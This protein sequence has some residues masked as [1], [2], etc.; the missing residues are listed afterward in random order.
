MTIKNS[1]ALSVLDGLNKL[2]GCKFQKDSGRLLY[3][4]AKNIRLLNQVRDDVTEAQKRLMKQHSEDRGVIMNGS[5]AAWQFQQA[6][7]QLMRQEAEVNLHKLAFGALLVDDN[8]ID[9]STL[10]KLDPIL[11][12][13]P[14][15]G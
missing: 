9:G 3:N 8:H 14:K 7:D 1:D 2:D 11:E 5:P 6:V 15:D 10:A 12:E 13:V 4:I